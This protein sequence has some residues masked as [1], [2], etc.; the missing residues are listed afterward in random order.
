[1]LVPSLLIVVVGN[2]RRSWEPLWRFWNKI[3]IHCEM[4]GCVLLSDWLKTL[5]NGIL[6]WYSFSHII[7][8][9]YFPWS[10]FYSIPQ[11]VPFGLV[12]WPQVSSIFIRTTSISYF[13]PTF[14][15]ELSWKHV[16]SS[17]VSWRLHITEW[18]HVWLSENLCRE[19]V[20]QNM[21]DDFGILQ[22][23]LTLCVS[24]IAGVFHIW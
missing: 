17:I 18:R 11:N 7:V 5:I 9:E 12:E 24:R 3:T 19:R 14:W 15:V 2:A 10:F 22:C 16:M 1:M 8:Y 23:W 6:Y 13:F 20:L 4:N 21:A